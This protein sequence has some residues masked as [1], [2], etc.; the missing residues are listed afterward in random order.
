MSKYTQ[1]QLRLMAQQALEHRNDVRFFDL[2]AL[3]SSQFQISYLSTIRK[4]EDLAR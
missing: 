4:I 3:L 2:M 1:D